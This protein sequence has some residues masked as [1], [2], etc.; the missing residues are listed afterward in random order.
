ML[1]VRDLEQRWLQYKIKSYYPYLFSL[2]GI[3]L[4]TISITLYNTKEEPKET[5]T[6]PKKKSENRQ[7]HVNT[8]PT[9]LA[10]TTSVTQ[11]PTVIPSQS[12]EPEP[13]SVA[14]KVNPERTTSNTY[15]PKKL[16]PSFSFL[17]KINTQPKSITPRETKKRQTVNTTITPAIE[18]E[19]PKIKEVQQKAK[20]TPKVQEQNQTPVGIKIDRAKTHKEIQD[21]IHRFKKRTNKDD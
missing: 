13:K 7:I 17:D 12:K 5:A 1:N 19:A 14:I 18:Q 2:L 9:V 10:N 6:T 11:V 3:L 15:T 20:V 4:L 16:E 8:Q 21:I